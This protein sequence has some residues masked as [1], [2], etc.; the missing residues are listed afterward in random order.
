MLLFITHWKNLVDNVEKYSFSLK[1]ILLV[2]GKVAKV[3]DP[4]ILIQYFALT[5]QIRF[6]CSIACTVGQEATH[7]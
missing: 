2:P 3:V 7:K 6:F 4:K 1:F 5:Q